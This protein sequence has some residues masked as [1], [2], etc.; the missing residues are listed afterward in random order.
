VLAVRPEPSGVVV[1]ERAS[2]VPAR[3]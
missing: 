2:A 1:P 3:V